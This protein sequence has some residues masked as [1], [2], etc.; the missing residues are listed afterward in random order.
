MFTLDTN[1]N[2]KVINLHNN[3]QKYDNISLPHECYIT[4]IIVGSHWYDERP[5][6]IRLLDATDDSEIATFDLIFF[7]LVFSVCSSF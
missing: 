4:K 7:Q 1:G 2:S 5:T 6:N 3:I